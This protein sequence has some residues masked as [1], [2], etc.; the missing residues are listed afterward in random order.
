MHEFMPPKPFL[1]L[2]QRTCP[3]YYLSLE[4]MFWVV[5]CHFVAA[6]DTLQ[7]LV[8]R[9]IY[10]TSLCLQNRFLFSSNEHAQSSTLG[11]KLMFSVVSWHV[12]DAPD[13]LRKLESACI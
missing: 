12:V 7:K 4:L 5:S 13:P 10:C 2:S 9:C 1:V 3:I 11:P 8:S 6:L